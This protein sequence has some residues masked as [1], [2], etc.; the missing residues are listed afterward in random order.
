MQVGR[1]WVFFAL[2][3]VACSSWAGS[4]QSGKSAPLF[5]LPVLGTPDAELSLQD[6]RGKVVYVDFWASWCAPCRRSFPV[7]NELRQ[8]YKDLGFEVI[9]ISVDEYKDDALAFQTELPVSYPLVWDPTGTL[10]AAFGVIGMPTGFLLDKTGVV[11]AVHEG[12]S[13]ED[14]SWLRARVLKLLES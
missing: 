2:F 11:Q 13:D 3:S 6:Y 10:L 1:F 5:K 7:L 4:I 12:F 9:A 8:Q 14:E